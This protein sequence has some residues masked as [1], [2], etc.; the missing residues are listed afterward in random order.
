ML[1]C[2]V[3]AVAARVIQL[4]PHLLVPDLNLDYPFT[5]GDSW[6]WLAN[7]LWWA[8]ADVRFSARA[9]LLPLLLAALE[10][11]HLLRFAPWIGIAALHAGALALYAALRRPCGRQAAAAGVLVVVAAY[12]VQSLALDLMADTLAAG[13]LAAALAALVAA[14]SDRRALAAAALLAG[15]A[16]VT[17]SAGPLFAP[18]L[19][20]AAL[21]DPWRTRARIAAVVGLFTAPTALWTLWKLWHFGTAGEVLVD[22]WTLLRLDLSA[23]LASSWFALSLLGLPAALL[24][25]AGLPLAIGSAR[26]DRTARL[27]ALA[28]LAPML[29]F[30]LCY[31]YPAKRFW[32]YAA[33]PATALLAL[34]FARLRPAVRWLAAALALA[35]ALL[36]L[37][38]PGRLGTRTAAWPLPPL[39]LTTALV[40]GP[41]G[42]PRLAPGGL[43]LESPSVKASLASAR[44]LLPDIP[45]AR[46]PFDAQ[47]LAGAQHALY[48]A[49]EADEAERY[50]LQ[51]R[52]GNALR[53]RVQWLAAPYAPCLRRFAV[54]PVGALRERVRLARFSAPPLSGEW[55]LATA[56][57]PAAPASPPPFTAADVAFAR[58]LADAVAG[59]PR[60]VLVLP[61]AP[62]DAACLLPLLLATTETHVFAA[63][64]AAAS[65]FL[66]ALPT[67]ASTDV[68]GMRIR[69]VRAAGVPA[70]V[71]DFGGQ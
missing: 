20:A 61:P 14:D 71:V 65:S 68:G 50:P 21:T 55:I 69:R 30:T 40:P 32:L 7:G 46:P 52:L 19:A 6:D 64:D 22:P 28:F 63:R 60:V 3:A 24:V 13:L 54:T 36:P 44:A 33:W 70:A 31:S 56:A 12:S 67:L 1:W 51:T 57:P 62:S 15:L 23:T 49:G 10:R 37:P 4:A 17:Q 43:A 16:A 39:L 26:S 18:V 29:F 42:G 5:D 41:N 8:G 48:V 9:P 47:A 2:L 58:A 59:V 53:R 27:A 11:L 38:E 45:V 34:L 35:G 25:V 66:R